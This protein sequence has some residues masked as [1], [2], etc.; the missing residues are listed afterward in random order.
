MIGSRDGFR[1]TQGHRRGLENR[2]AK[3]DCRPRADGARRRHRRGPGARRAGR[4]ARAMAGR[5][6]SR[7]IPGAWLM[8]AAKH[9][10]I[11]YFRRN[12]MLHRK[13]EQL[14]K[15]LER[16]ERTAPDYDTA[17]DRAPRQAD[18]VGDDLLRLIF[19][20]CH[21]VLSAEARVALTLRLLGGL[22]TD[23][24]ARAFLV[25][26][27]TIAQRIVRAKTH[28]HKGTGAVRGAA[29]RRPRGAP[30][31]GARG[32]L[33]HF[34]RG[35]LRNRRRRMD[36]AGAVRRR[37]AARADSCGARASGGGGARPRRAD[38]DSGVA[39]AG[40]RERR[41]RADPPSR[42][43]PALSGISCSSAAV[44]P[45]SRR[46]ETLGGARGRYALQA[47]IAACHA[48]ARTADDTDWAR[49]ARLYAELAAIAP[50]PVVDLNR[51]VAVGDGARPGRGARDRRHADLAAVDGRL[52]PAARRPRRPAQQ[53]RPA[54]TRPAWSS[55]A[56]RRLRVTHASARCCSIAPRRA[57]VRPRDR[58]SDRRHVRAVPPF[59]R[60]PPRKAGRPAR[61]ARSPACSAPSRR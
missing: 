11:D 28:A 24:I 29:R 19:T 16:L 3:G 5:R 8:A 34:Q 10:A 26:E 59:L 9:R 42:S 7:A 56:R 17:L 38:G 14:V 32:H 54:A 13:H 4:G 30:L 22:T 40:A 55:S 21:P 41:R 43:E 61:S 47:S 53:A 50:S 36:A 52:S 31:V 2:V 44:S 1:Y 60:Q 20:A 25:S 35:L 15:E 37:A 12:T 18:D 51:A 58:S 27:P 45:R 48:R 46:A 6:A 49:I 57:P 33:S 23:E 39:D